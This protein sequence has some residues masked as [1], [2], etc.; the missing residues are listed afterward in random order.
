MRMW[1]W[2]PPLSVSS[3][4]SWKS[5]PQ[6]KPSSTWSGHGTWRKA[7]AMPAGRGITASPGKWAHLEQ[8]LLLL[9]TQLLTAFPARQLCRHL[10]MAR[11]GIAKKKRQMASDG[12][13]QIE[14]RLHYSSGCNSHLAAEQ[15][16]TG[17]LEHAVSDSAA[18]CRVHEISGD[19]VLYDFWNAADTR[20]EHRFSMRHRF[21]NRK[22]KGLLPH[23]KLTNQVT[24]R[25]GAL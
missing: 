7:R 9:A 18:V 2:S 11:F 21:C 5:C 16:I 19:T 20:G 1:S 3:R 23:G 4:R 25:E 15:L 6:V 14:A 24:G 13:G 17:E 8:P 12:V 10:Q 22:A